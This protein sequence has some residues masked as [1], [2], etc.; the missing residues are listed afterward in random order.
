MSF[1]LYKALIVEK[2]EPT[3]EQ[4]FREGYNSGIF[5]GKSLPLWQDVPDA[6]EKWQDMQDSSWVLYQRYLK[7][8]NHSMTEFRYKAV[9]QAKKIWF[10]KK[11]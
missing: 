7:D 1:F 11:D 5:I 9:K 8:E 3:I 2:Q 10:E 4:A 6:V